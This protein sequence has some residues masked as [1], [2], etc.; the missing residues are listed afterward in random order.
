MLGKI[1]GCI[2]GT[3][4][5]LALQ[6]YYWVIVG[7]LL[8]LCIGY[9]IDLAI[10]Y[11][12]QC[13][14]AFFESLFLIT[15]Y[16]AQLDGT[17]S[18]P[19]TAVS[20]SIMETE[21]KLSQDKIDSAIKL[22]NLGTHSIFNL[23]NT[24]KKFMKY[25]KYR[26]YCKMIFLDIL[27][28]MALADG[29]LHEKEQQLLHDICKKINIKEKN[30]DKI[31]KI[32]STEYVLDA[33]HLD[34]NNKQTK[35]NPILKKSEFTAALYILESDPKDSKQQIIKQYKK[36]YAAYTPDK[37]ISQGL[38]KEMADFVQRKKNKINQAYKLIIG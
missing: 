14:K 7:G 31:I 24:I 18:Y 28:K 2:I 30:L 5:F 36:L 23:N 16:I 26:Y 34:T 32:N 6:L 9:F 37:L 17:I 4:I 13:D 12:S 3:S 29:H 10:I 11:Y 15:G 19:E 38:P 8:G 33:M 20:K 21:L 1:L 35:T 22:Y 25:F 27:V